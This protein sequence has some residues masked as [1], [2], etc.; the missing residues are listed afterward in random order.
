MRELVEQLAAFGGITAARPA[1]EPAT[2]LGRR[3]DRPYSYDAEIVVEHF[4]DRRQTVGRARCIGDD[5]MLAWILVGIVHPE[6]ESNV[7]VGGGGGNDHFLGAG[8]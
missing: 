6:N 2:A 1:P 3:G 4:G 8:A 7:F 5:M